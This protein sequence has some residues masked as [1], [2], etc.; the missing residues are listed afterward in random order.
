MGCGA[1]LTTAA[2][3][4]AGCGQEAVEPPATEEETAAVGFESI[5]EVV[6][7]IRAL[8]AELEALDDQR[9]TVGFLGLADPYAKVER[10][11]LVSIPEEAVASGD[12]E[13][14]RGRVAGP[15]LLLDPAKW[16]AASPLELVQSARDS[17]R[18]ERDTLRDRIDRLSSP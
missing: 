10:S 9:A 14:L 7:G 4:V 17:F 5:E 13:P 11:A 15:G 2:V 3:V 8:A 12:W 1:V 6:E 16:E 18:L